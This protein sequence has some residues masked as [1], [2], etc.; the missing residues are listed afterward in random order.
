MEKKH[1]A[2]KSESRVIMI[3]FL[4]LMVFGILLLVIVLNQKPV[5]VS[6]PYTVKLVEDTSTPEVVQYVWHVVVQESARTSELKYIAEQL[7]GEAK[8]GTSFNALVIMMYDYPEYIGYG[9][10]L[11]KV[12]FAPEGDTRKANTVNTGD[13]DKMSLQ[14]DLREKDWNKQLTVDEAAIWK[15][16]HE[17]YESQSADGIV[18]DKS[19]VNTVI[20]DKYNLQLSNLN[21]ILLKQEYWRYNN[22][23]YITR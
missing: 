12:V 10:T 2:V 21:N 15:A 7:I 11:G 5:N 9:F 20:A 23:S 8:R 14:W 17:F 22:L 16:W 1:T 18:P 3:Y 6:I 13:Y 4:I 19:L